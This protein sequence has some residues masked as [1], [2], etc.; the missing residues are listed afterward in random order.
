MRPP[1]SRER[2][3]MQPF[4]RKPRAPRSVLVALAVVTPLVTGVLAA[5]QALAGT[6][7]ARTTLTGTRPSWAATSSDAGTVPADTTQSVRVYLA[8]SDPGGLARYAL[9]VSTP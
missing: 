5:P 7:T 6:A 8:G 9:A 4:R 1:P 3:I 2:F